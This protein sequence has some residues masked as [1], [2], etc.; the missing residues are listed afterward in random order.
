MFNFREA[1]SMTKDLR[2]LVTFNVVAIM[3]ILGVAT[4]A[5]EDGGVMTV[6]PVDPVKNAECKD[7]YCKGRI[8]SIGSRS[9]LASHCTWNAQTS[10]CLGVCYRCDDKDGVGE[11]DICIKITGN[12]ECTPTGRDAQFVCEDGTPHKCES[13]SP[14]VGTPATDSLSC[15]T[16]DVAT[17]NDLADGCK[18]T[19]CNQP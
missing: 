19:K 4:F 6:S 15:C 13:T 9:E 18:F 17:G 16:D 1:T 8:S 2:L 10:T 3:T 14:G 7:A 12:G 11:M 5:D